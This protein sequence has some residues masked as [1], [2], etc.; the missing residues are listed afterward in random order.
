MLRWHVISG[1]FFR[2]V[3]QFFTSVIGYLFIVVFVTLCAILTFSPQFFAD[4][5][6]NLDQLSRYFPWLLLF[7][8][9]AI[10]MNIWA[11]ERKQGTDA[12]LFT[13][14]ASDLEILLGKFFSVV[15][16]YTVA[17]LFSL[18]QV[19]ALYFLGEPDP[20]VVV[21][22]Y[23]GYW[24]AGVALLSIGMFASSL[25][26]SN[27][28]AFIIGAA[29]C[30]I[31][32]TMG[33]Y[34]GGFRVIESLSIPFHIRDFT[35]GLVSFPGVI[36]FVSIIVFMLY[37]NLVVITKRH[38]SR[39]QSVSLA[40]HFGV[41]IIALAVGLIALNLVC[42]DS[43]KLFPTRTDLTSEKLYTLNQTTIDTLK[44]ARENKRRV[45][46]QAYVSSNVPRKYV[47]TRKNFIG[48]L[49]QYNR[50]GGKY[51]DVNLEE[52]KPASKKAK[53]A[54]TQQMEPKQV[55]ESIGG[56]NIE[57]DFYMGALVSSSLGDSVL[58]FVDNDVSLE[59][60][61][62]RAIAATT[63]DKAKLRIGVL[64][65]DYHFDFF[66]YEN[67]QTGLEEPYNWGFAKTFDLLERHYD[68][69]SI[70]LVKLG[71]FADQ[72]QSEQN[73]TNAD[74]DGDETEAVEADEVVEPES[75][76]R[77]QDDSEAGQ[78][79]QEL[80][81]L[82]VVDPSSL[83]NNSMLDLITYIESG[84]PV[85]ILADPLPFYW[86]S[87]NPTM[88][89]GMV[90]APSQPR[91]SAGWDVTAISTEPKSNLGKSIVDLEQSDYKISYTVRFGAPDN[92]SLKTFFR[93]QDPENHWSV[94][95]DD[96]GTIQLLK[97]VGG[98]QEVVLRR[99]SMEFD[100]SIPAEIEITLNGDNV[101]LH[102]GIIREEL[103]DDFNSQQTQAGI[104]IR[105]ENTKLESFEVSIKEKSSAAEFGEGSLAP[106]QSK[107]IFSSEFG[108]R[109]S[110]LFET[111]GIDWSFDQAAWQRYNPHP[112]FSPHVA[113]IG[114]SQWPD[115]YG[116][117]DNLFLF[118]RP[119]AGFDVFNRADSISAGLKE[120]MFMY[121]GAVR[122]L[123]NSDLEFT[124]L[125]TLKPGESGITD[126]GDLT[127]TEI[128]EQFNRM[129]GE[130]TEG[131]LVSPVT[132]SEFRKMVAE[133]NNLTRSDEAL[134]LAARITGD[135]VNVV[136]IAD[137]DFLCDYYHE[138]IEH[139][140]QL[141][142]NF[143]LLT[144]A[145]ESLSSNETFVNLRNRRPDPRTLTRFETITETYRKDRAQREETM[146]LRKKTKLVEA[147]ERMDMVA[148][149]LSD[150]DE[151]S[152]LQ[153]MN[154]A[155][156]ESSAAQV[157]YESEVA[158]LE[159]VFAES[160]EDIRIDEQN[161]IAKAES[162][163]R[164][165]TILLAPIPALVLGVV[166]LLFRRTLESF[167]ISQDR[168]V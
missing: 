93:Y 85:L 32:V 5:L 53:E 133:P 99:E 11:E 160:M 66:R 1:F 77:S 153:K 96:L 59:Y 104:E 78:S 10:T 89:I 33:Y 9:P 7:I 121:P 75:D 90:N 36:Y 81:V 161:N 124:S 139:V 48:L 44:N 125:I 122:P 158:R 56:R 18:T 65:S 84:K 128:A 21:S 126:V 144:N 167:G 57:Q 109:C 14:P 54:K 23:V 52:V 27:T 102:A 22:T 68:V 3:K 150:D 24:L 154:S 132:G 162:F 73:K 25:T 165:W 135:N 156:M 37:L 86:V 98:E 42:D 112:G 94:T 51:V 120:V 97:T 163:V 30:A 83:P 31:P 152:I 143:T 34:F 49:R 29:L 16:V 148:D 62:T 70:D 157:K 91:I 87:L 76:E 103:T 72:I 159:E 6:A 58:P 134:H 2:N 142:D 26:S 131:P 82:V 19:V 138:Q 101:Q 45:T 115:E 35:I 28:V 119:L 168:K 50:I 67:P 80:D 55:Q 147:Q 39:G 113:A 4:N 38:W 108:G 123:P 105:S 137:T 127:T 13:L 69:D 140:D 71:E 20:G 116:P 149:R 46:V 43:S 60:E 12:L 166:V 88:P 110:L 74:A 151:M 92:N 145:I 136:V 146:E 117:K 61:L 141:L 106:L 129:T 130:I 47:N 40:S 114:V 8:I 111:L 15:A 107:V 17:L 100:S 164:F 79:K 95:I 64:D 155:K 118:A 63:D 41:R